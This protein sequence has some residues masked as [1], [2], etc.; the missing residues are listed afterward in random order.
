MRRWIAGIGLG[1]AVI[2]L[3]LAFASNVSSQLGSEGLRAEAEERLSESI[4][5]PASI[6]HLRVNFGFGIEIEAFDVELWRHAGGPRLRISRAVARVK[7]VP[8]L[9]GRIELG[10]LLLDGPRL[11]IERQVDGTWSP[12]LPVSFSSLGKPAP[13]PPSQEPLTALEAAFRSLLDAPFGADRLAIRNGGIHFIDALTHAQDSSGADLQ[14]ADPHGRAQEPVSLLFQ[15]IHGRLR[16]GRIRGDAQLTLGARIF[17]GAV[18]RGTLQWESRLSRNGTL[19]VTLKV[20]SL[21]LPAVAPYLR[22][23]SPDVHLE[24]FVSGTIDLETRTPKGAAPT[25]PRGWAGEAEVSGMRIRFGDATWLQG[26]SGGI[27]WSEDRIEL[28]E[29]RADFRG[30]QLPKLDLTFTGVSNMLAAHAQLDRVRSDPIPLPG[31]RTLWK[32]LHRISIESPTGKP[33]GSP[34]QG[35]LELDLLEHPVLLWPIA[36]LR[37]LIELRDYGVHIVAEE[38][39]WGG[40]PIRGDADWRV[41]PEV[42]F[43]VRLAASPSVSPKAESGSPLLDSDP[44]PSLD[45]ERAWARGR[46]SI[47]AVEGPTWFQTAAQGRVRAF[48]SELQ[49]VDLQI[50]LS[51]SGRLGGWVGLDLRNAN[52]VACHGSLEVTG[53]D[54]ATLGRAVGMPE[55]LA[56][57]RVDLSGSFRASLQPEQSLLASPEGTFAVR[58][59]QG[60]F[61]QSLPP[62]VAIVQ[63]SKAFNPAASDPQIRYDRVETVLEFSE[64]HLITQNFTFE[65]PEMRVLVEGEVDLVDPSHPLHAQVTLILFRQMGRALGKIPILG[66]LLLGSDN[67]LMAAYF[68]LTG[69][70]AEPKAKLVPLRSLATSPP[71]LVIEGGKMLAQLPLRMVKSIQAMIERVDRRPKPPPPAARP[72]SSDDRSETPPSDS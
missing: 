26:M 10:R 67:S 47:G 42:A 7:L 9:F 22:A 8:L 40:V 37:A 14:G 19:R 66:L 56:T 20:T 15:G 13:G 12:P 71:G 33:T 36:N 59:T 30:R 38:G 27:A 34:I 41:E 48:G 32:V 31:F 17:D 5:S 6:G 21:A 46:F 3:A 2:A 16:H 55:G 62:M 18:D 53:G 61:R 64:G 29:V 52:R 39:T 72:S 24:G 1:L 23:L 70:W 58:I 11:S 35:Q 45:G 25:F 28:R 54:V 63:E 69:T 51:P 49:I 60:A 43:S 57:G 68:E 44:P 4:G 50:D 65:G